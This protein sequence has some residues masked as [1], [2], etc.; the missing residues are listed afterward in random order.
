MIFCRIIC[1]LSFVLLVNGSKD[2]CNKLSPCKCQHSRGIVDISSLSGKNFTVIDKGIFC[3]FF[4]CEQGKNWGKG[5]AKADNN[6]VCSNHST[7]GRNIQSW[8][9]EASAEFLVPNSIDYNSIMV[10]FHSGE[11]KTELYLECAKESGEDKFTILQVQH[12]NIQLR[13]KSQAACY[14]PSQNFRFNLG[15]PGACYLFV[16]III[17]SLLYFALLFSIGMFWRW[18]RNAKGWGPLP[19]LIMYLKLV[20]DGFLFTFSCFPRCRRAIGVE[21][22]GYTMIQ[23]EF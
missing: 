22:G 17:L 21:S 3:I 18:K 23:N 7:N 5:C 15:K 1:L 4:P 14:T 6:A 9:T 20:L 10:K 8:G 2:A 12:D 13:L 19:T 16:T 11:M